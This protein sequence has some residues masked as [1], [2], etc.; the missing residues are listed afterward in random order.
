MKGSA[1]SAS[2]FTNWIR[3]SRNFALQA[4]DHP[5]NHDR[6]FGS[7]RPTV[8]A[9]SSC[10]QRWAAGGG[11]RHDWLRQ[12][13]SVSSPGERELRRYCSVGRKPLQ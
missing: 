6:I 10:P 9:V 4:T 5:I 13:L 7:R 3:S 2:D 12:L 8:N 1:R 11:F